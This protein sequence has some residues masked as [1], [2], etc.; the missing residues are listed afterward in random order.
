MYNR[1]S[2]GSRMEPWGTPALT[3][4]FFEDFPS[5]KPEAVYY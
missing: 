4:Y 5:K 3:G 2:V 1:K